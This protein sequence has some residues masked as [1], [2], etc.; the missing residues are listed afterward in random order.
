MR[1]NKLVE[2]WRAPLIED[3]YGSKR[4]WPNAVRVASV[5]GSVQPYQDSEQAIDR[6]TT[7][8]LQRVYLRP[9]GMD[10]ESTDRVLVDGLWYEVDGVPRDWSEFRQ[11]TRHLR[12]IIR[13]VAL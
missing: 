12:L 6:E 4:D 10:I 3:A 11:K 1:F 8:T 5:P 2:I 13:R 9:L 7:K